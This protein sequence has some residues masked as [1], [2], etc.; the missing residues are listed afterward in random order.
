MIKTF[1]QPDVVGLADVGGTIW[2]THWAAHQVGT[3]DPITNIFT[4]VFNTPDD[5]GALAFDP[6]SDLLWVGQLG[7]QIIPYSLL[8]VPLGPG[9]NPIANNPG[10][11]GFNVDTIDGLTFQGEGT[12]PVPE[13][14]SI[15][16]LG[17]ALA[18]LG[19][20]R[21]PRRSV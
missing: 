14:A 20:M 2:M 6:S 10:F 12:Q 21:R 5:A 11:N 9:F 19:L 17:T 8:G 18:G 13:P 16:I 15:V 1:A 7:G 4:P 3:W